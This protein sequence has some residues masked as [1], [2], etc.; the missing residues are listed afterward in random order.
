M[1]L[2]SALVLAGDLAGLDR[3]AA[4]AKDKDVFR[5]AGASLANKEKFEGALKL[6]QRARQL[7]PEQLQVRINLAYVYEQL[8]RAD[9]AEQTFREA[10]DD[11]TLKR[12]PL[13]ASMLYRYG[14]FLQQ[15]PGRQRDA[16][17]VF[18]DALS[19]NLD[20]ESRKAITGAAA[21]LQAKLSS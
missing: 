6:L 5:H 15:Q 1:G 10:K 7:Q 2:A 17:A 11:V 20:V 21:A 18:N 16:M 13:F 12:D 3:L 19:L 14:L 4:E 8:K 9:M